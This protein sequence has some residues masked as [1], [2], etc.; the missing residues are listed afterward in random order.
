MSESERQIPEAVKQELI[1]IGVPAEADDRTAIPFVLIGAAARQ[2]CALGG[3]VATALDL[4]SSIADVDSSDPYWL[5]GPT[6]DATD[7]KDLLLDQVTRLLRVGF[8]E[9]CEVVL[10]FDESY[11]ATA[12]DDDAVAVARVE[13][14]RATALE[15]TRLLVTHAF[16]PSR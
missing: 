9:I 16:Q 5:Q 13:A 8:N 14:A 7:G 3:E 10:D 4:L 15:A 12:P 1:T 2:I 11:D 6:P